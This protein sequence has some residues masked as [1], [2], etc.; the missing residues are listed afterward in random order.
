MFGKTVK[1]AIKRKR[2]KAQNTPSD[3]A[4]KMEARSIVDTPN[5]PGMRDVESGKAGKVT[6]GESSYLQTISAKSARKKQSIKDA[7][8]AKEKHTKK[9]K[10][11]ETRIKENTSDKSKTIKER[12][13][14]GR[15][16]QDQLE[17]KKDLLQQAQDKIRSAS[18]KYGGK[19]M[20]KK[21]AGGK[22]DSSYTVGTK[23]FADKVKKAN[24]AKKKKVNKKAGGGRMSRVG[25]SPAEESRSGV[26]SEADRKS[27]IMFG[28]KK[29]GQV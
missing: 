13:A 15:K 11:L 12:A 5:Y 9:I 24:D 10:S 22:I 6:V 1:T 7:T 8:A 21:K 4:R 29:G 19:V 3:V 23:S 27:K 18:R 26:M 2:N 28:Y 17:S 25:L 14:I 16:L 20:K